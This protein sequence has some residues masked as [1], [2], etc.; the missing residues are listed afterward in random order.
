MRCGSWKYQIDIARANVPKQRNPFT[1]FFQTIGIIE[2]PAYSQEFFVERI[3]ESRDK[4]RVSM[5]L[6]GSLYECIHALQKTV[7]VRRPYVGICTVG[8]YKFFPGGQAVWTSS[9]LG[10]ER[11]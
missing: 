4:M 7:G 11:E 8:F 1:S 10:S 6:L 9:Y 2:A 5:L 3:R